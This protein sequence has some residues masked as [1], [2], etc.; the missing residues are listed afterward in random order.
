MLRRSLFFLFFFF[1]LTLLGAFEYPR[2]LGDEGNRE[3]AISIEALKTD[4][5]SRRCLAEA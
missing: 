3:V 1:S 4:G 2:G 5:S